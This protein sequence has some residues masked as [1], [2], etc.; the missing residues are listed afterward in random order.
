MVIDEINE[1]FDLSKSV[2]CE[3]ASLQTRTC[4]QIISMLDEVP[5][6][7]LGDDVGMGKT[8]VAFSTAVYFLYKYPGKKI[9]VITPNWLLNKKWFN[10]IRNFIA[11]NLKKNVLKLREEDIKQITQNHNGDYVSQIKKASKNGKVLLIPIN[12][13]S[14][15]GWKREMSFYLSCWFKHRKFWGKTRVAIL[16]RMGGNTE[17]YAPEDTHDMGIS[18][19]E[20]PEDWYEELDTIYNSEGFT[21]ES[22]DKIWEAIKLLRYKVINMVIPDA[23]LLILDE[24]HK[25]KNAD[26]VKRKSLMAGIENKFEKGIFLTATPFQLGEGELKSVLDMF[27]CSTCSIEEKVEFDKLTDSLFSEINLYMDYMTA[28]ESYVHDMSTDEEAMLENAIRTKSTEGL[29]MDVIETYHHYETLLVQKASLEKVMLRVIVRNVK[30]KDAYRKEIIGAMENDDRNGLPLS[31]EAYIP[32]ALME[33]AI[34]QIL[35]HG[36]RTFIANIKQ[37]F[38]SSFEAMLDSSIM[39]RDIQAIKMISKI[40]LDKVSHPKV[41][42]VCRKAVDLLMHGEKVLI[43]CNRI[44]TMIKLRDALQRELEKNI[45]RDI[46]MLFPETGKKGFDNYCKRFYSKQD[47]SWFLLQENYIN[48]ILIPVLRT[49]GVNERIIPKASDISEEVN[50]LYR[51]FN[52]SNKTNYMYVKRIVEQIV[53]RRVFNNI[54][55]WYKELQ[56]QT[57]LINTIYVIMDTNYIHLGLSIEKRDNDDSD[58]GEEDKVIRHI[59]EKTINNVL[60]YKGIWT[61]YS[62]Y[63]NKI[64]PGQREDIVQSM[65]AFLRRDRRFFIQLRK[66]QDRYAHKKEDYSFLIRKTF[67][68]GGVLDWKKA[69]ARFLKNYC[70]AIET[71]GVANV[72]DMNLGLRNVNIVDIINASTTNDRRKII[73]AGFNTPFNPQILIVTETMQEGIDLQKECKEVIH[74]DMEWNP[75]SMEQRVGRIDRIGSLISE[76]RS[77]N[78]DTTLD[79]YYP[80]I[81]NTID[82]SIYNTVKDREKWFN[83]ILGGTPQWDTFEVDPSITQIQPWVFKNLQVDLS[84]R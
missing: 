41:S 9:V 82:E 14:S 76:M 53:F 30:N 80:F 45:N 31:E 5:G 84:V 66:M 25:M 4:A 43:F 17:V 37:S 11:Q 78:N 7:I 29:S 61:I 28:F 81:K 8:Y 32:Y 47:V 10:D 79:I 3:T 58:E 12:V 60:K 26:T 59:D 55:G 34:Y 46:K 16:Q 38:T 36:D 42:N 40:K 51:N 35:E 39:K 75:A 73:Q 18:Y 49:L 63:L 13:F 6:I 74:Y 54:N 83:L 27:K 65:I 71:S 57:N 20:I 56:D 15:M 64:K 50:I 21:E 67:E 68:S 22:V 48:S 72:E 77:E 2:N 1:L 52:V 23:S 19:N 44:E 62:D 33:K 70:I 69:Y 24:A